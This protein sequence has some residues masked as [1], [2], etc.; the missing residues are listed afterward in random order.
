MRTQIRRIGVAAMLSVWLLAIAAVPASAQI[1]ASFE[2]G[3]TESEGI[4]ASQSRIVLGSVYNSLDITRGGSFGFTVGGFFT[5]NWEAE[6]LFNRQ[7][8]SLEISDPAPTRK[9]A[10]QNVDN[11]HGNLVYNF[12]THESRLRPFLFGGLGATHYVPGDF[13]ASLPVSSAQARINGFSKFS[14][15]W[16]GGIK[17]YFSPVVGVKASLRWTPTYIKS[18]AD[19]LWCD[20]FYPT[21]WV[22]GNADYSNQ[23]AFSGG[24]TFRFGGPR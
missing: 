4:N 8:S 12:G 16:G 22:I 14:S 17:A 3:Y 19:G 23:L 5:E 15:T 10:N 11:Y 1:E 9:I 6:F 24:V 7:F 2:A 21:C 18:D 20:P 13:D